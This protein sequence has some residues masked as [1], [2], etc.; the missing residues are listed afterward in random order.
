MPTLKSR[1][2]LM[3]IVTVSGGH[4]KAW[5][6]SNVSLLQISSEEKLGAFKT[7]EQAINMPTCYSAQ[8]S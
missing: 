4:S 5:L 7:E 2:F 6:R 1:N 8:F 3:E